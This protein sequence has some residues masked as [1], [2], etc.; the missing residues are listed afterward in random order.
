MKV[1]FIYSFFKTKQKY[2]LF[3]MFASGCRW[4]FI[5]TITIHHG[6]G[7]LKSY[8]TPT[9]PLPPK[10]YFAFV[11]LCHRCPHQKIIISSLNTLQQSLFYVTFIK[12]IKWFHEFFVT[13]NLRNCQDTEF[14]YLF[15]CTVNVNNNIHFHWKKL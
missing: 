7:Y 11:N 4:K 10:N 12:F 9:V 2:A 13:T 6:R 5:H 15:L 14:V 3:A 1:L 8:A